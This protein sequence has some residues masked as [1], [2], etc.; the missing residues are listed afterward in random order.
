M[1]II[2]ALGSLRQ[3]DYK[4]EESLDYIARPYFKNETNRP[5]PQNLEEIGPLQTFNSYSP[6]QLSAANLGSLGSYPAKQII[7]SLVQRSRNS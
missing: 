5:P 1:T 3:K 4:F 6:A 7:V 2:L